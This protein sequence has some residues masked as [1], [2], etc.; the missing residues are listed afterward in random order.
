[1]AAPPPKLKR[2]GFP[3]L[4]VRQKSRIISGS[5]P[6]VMTATSAQPSLYANP[7]A[8]RHSTSKALCV[9]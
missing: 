9:T 6:Q 5:S 7:S 4:L 8:Q 2:S 1:M 3:S